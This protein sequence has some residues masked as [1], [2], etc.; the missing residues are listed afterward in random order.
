MR[1]L[2][3]MEQCNPDWASVPSVAFNIYQELR[4]LADV[5]PGS[6]ARNREA[7]AARGLDGIHFIEESRLAARYY[8]SLRRLEGKDLVWPLHHA[9]SYPVYAEFDQRVAREF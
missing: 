3:V 6:H 9:L 7:L 4:E 2:C 5:T 8:R 1:V